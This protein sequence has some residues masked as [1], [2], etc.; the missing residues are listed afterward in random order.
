V[1]LSAGRTESPGGRIDRYQWDLD[2]NGTWDRETAAPAT[3]IKWSDK[4][5]HL[6]AVRVT[7]DDGATDVG[8]LIVPV[9]LSPNANPTCTK[10]GTPNGDRLLGTSRRDVLCGL[11]GDDLLIGLGGNDV[12]IGGPGK[13]RLSGGAGKDE[14]RGGPGND[15]LLGG[16][17][18]DRLFGDAGRDLLDGQ[19]GRDKL[20]AKDRQRDVVDG[21]AGK[22]WARVD[23][24]L[25][26][27][28]GVERVSR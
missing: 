23:R 18:A 4:G 5:N 19:T 25:D 26:R 24:R 16:S 27:R 9:S 14:L 28:H 1:T 22:D 8:R 21:G 17:G 11:G 12:L 6:V 3:T 15:T 13:D 7:D 10:V 20:Y 2:G